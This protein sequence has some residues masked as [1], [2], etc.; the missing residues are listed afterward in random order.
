MWVNDS[1]RC[2]CLCAHGLG[3]I[4]CYMCTSASVCVWDG[5][6]VCV[7]VCVCVHVCAI[8]G[9][10]ASFAAL[11]NAPSCKTFPGIWNNFTWWCKQLK[12]AA[13]VSASPP[14]LTLSLYAR[15][16]MYAGATLV[17]FM[18]VYFSSSVIAK[19]L[20]LLEEMCVCKQNPLYCVMKKSG[21]YHS[22]AMM[23]FWL[24]ECTCTS[25][26][27]HT[28]THT[29]TNAHAETHISLCEVQGKL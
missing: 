28:H 16:L 11:I 4:Q 15:A 29:H 10:T 9:S 21:L 22:L 2:V 20:I 3:V 27:P 6:C 23:F 1:V 12:T 25:M 19:R 24:H 7:C 13:G 8:R 5:V 18:P 14:H 17:V 26:Q